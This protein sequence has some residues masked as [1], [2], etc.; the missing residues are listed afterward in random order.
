MSVTTVLRD[1][2]RNTRRS[3]VVLGVIAVL[4]VFV[5]LIVG[6]DA[7]AHDYPYRALFDVSFFFFLALPLIITPLTYLAVAGDRDSGAIKHAL[8]LPNTRA[9]YLTA[10]YISRSA[11]AVAGILVALVVGFVV[12]TVAYPNAPDPVRFL[13]FGAVSALFALSMTGIFVAIS[14][15]TKA[16]S[17]AMFGVITAY[18]VLG[19]FWLGFLP[20]V[21]LGT[22]IDT[23]TSTL[24]VT[25]TDQTMGLIQSLSPT[26]AYLQST[27]FV[28]AGVLDNHEMIARNFQ[29]DEYY[30][31]LWFNS[32]VM[33]AW[34]A[35]T[36]GIGYV[37]FRVAELG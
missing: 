37:R 6:S 20:V 28:Y 18:F 24:G 11:V 15:M 29:G 17:R 32:L 34:A 1:D 9:E 3:F 12:A 16:R 19:P 4:T 8:G 7:S 21:N 22:I 13:K 23:V 10:K 35:V 14:S 2:V 33:G 36:L 30:T 27:E 31:K 5:G 25:L 26:V